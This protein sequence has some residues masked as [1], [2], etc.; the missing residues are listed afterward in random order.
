[1]GCL[2]VLNVKFQLKEEPFQIHPK[3][4]RESKSDDL[5][6]KLKLSS[7]FAI[8]QLAFLIISAKTIPRKKE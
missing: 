6:S 3:M 5:I 1:M 8:G 7:T 4:Q 2:V